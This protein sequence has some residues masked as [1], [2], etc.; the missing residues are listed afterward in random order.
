MS[1]PYF[2]MFPTDFE[3]DTSHLTLAEDGAYNRLLRL[4]WM[5]PGCSLPDDDGWILR[6]MR[7]HS[8]EDRA[9]VIGIIDEF[10]T[11]KN[12]RVSNA[13]LAKEYEAAKDAHEKRVSAGS[14]GGKAKALKT[15]E[16]ESSNA[17][18]KPKQ[19]S[20]NQ[21]QNQNHS[22]R[23]ANASPKVVGLPF[24]AF[25]EVWPSKKS[26]HTAERAWKKLGPDDR[27]QV[28]AHA[29]NWFSAWQASH[30]TASPI[31]AA[32]FLNNR[33]WEDDAFVRRAPQRETYADDFR[34]RFAAQQQARE[35]PG[36]GQS[37][38]PF[39]L[40]AGGAA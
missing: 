7:C 40:I 38:E 11:R 39:R 30:P 9:V 27:V 34:R 21:N 31:L 29:A 1:L 26:K 13:R 28:V 2:P 5:T 20:S 16:T 35:G 10:F 36:G 14:R 23:D 22:K 17:L 19:C 4:A 6:R 24:S 12:G 18:A 15:K 8:D 32:T 3:A 33:R 37:Q 25:W